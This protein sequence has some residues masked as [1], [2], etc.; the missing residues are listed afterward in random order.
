MSD[1]ADLDGL[2]RLY[3]TL[4]ARQQSL[5]DVSYTARLLSWG[6]ERIAQKVGEEAVEVVIEIATGNR[7]RLAAESADLL[8]HLSVAW[9]ALGLRPAEIY[10]ELAARESRS[11]ADDRSDPVTEDE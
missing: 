8:Y 7:A 3:A 11:S 2:E 5:P 1:R 4:V 10:A 6:R 9:L